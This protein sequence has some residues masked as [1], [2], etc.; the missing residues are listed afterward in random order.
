[1]RGQGIVVMLVDKSPD[2]G[3]YKRNR[4]CPHLAKANLKLTLCGSSGP[5]L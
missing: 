2:V 4:V 3:G 5:F 1:M